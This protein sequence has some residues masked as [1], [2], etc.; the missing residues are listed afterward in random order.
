M[1]ISK[2]IAIGVA[3]AFFSNFSY[4]QS[5]QEGIASIDSHKYAKAKKNFEEM[6]SNSASAENYFY[7]GN[8]YLTQT[9]PDFAKAEEYF[10]KGLAADNKDYLNKIG[11]ATVKLGKGNKAAAVAEIQRIV[12]DSRERDPEVLF[13]A[14]QA[15]TLFEK[16][17]DAN[18][19]VEFLNKAI[20]KA[21]RKDVPAHYYYTLGDAF[22]LKLTNSPQ[23]AGDAMTAYERALPVADNKASVY[24]RMGTLWMQAQQWQR[25]RQE[26]TK[27]IAADP[28]YAPAYK[29]LANYE[30]RFQQGQNATKALE[31]YAKYADE[32]PDT[33]LEIAK[34]YFTNQNY[35]NSRATLEKVFPLVQDPIKFKLRAYLNYADQNYTQAQS[36]LNTFI[37]TVTDK[38]R[39]FPA[40]RGLEGLIIAGLSKNEN[41]ES[42]KSAMMQEAQQKITI[43]KN[44]KDQT[45]DWDAELMKIRGGGADVAAAN[46]G[47]TNPTIEA[48]KR[49][50]AANPNDVDAI[51]KLG[52]AYQEVEN[53]NG[54]ILTWDKMIALSPTWAYSYYAKGVSYQQLANPE[55]AE[56]SY[57]KF[58]DTVLAQKPEEQA[59]QRET[60]SYAYYAVAYYNL[61]KNPEKARDY[62]AKAV[63]LKPDYQDAVELNNQLNSNS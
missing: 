51:V 59:Q 50:I 11:L 58:I 38:S 36:D 17:S 26:I 13:R 41:D 56:A 19:A 24:T 34:L 62:A 14:G 35:A 15:L 61:T 4:A 25:A 44:A 46:A 37:T 5:L 30:I 7:L 12:K 21:S 28:T 22:R 45:L 40:D 47:P 2:K 9:E 27:A 43:A 8:T 10:R 20:E 49:Q 31:N 16:N 39:I 53:W 6:V 32:D 3:V 23:V 55:M 48:L 33:Q 29:A 1:N 18:L 63:Q 54:S 42:K 57:Q 52:A 60:L